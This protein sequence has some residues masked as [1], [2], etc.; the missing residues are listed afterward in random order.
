[1]QARTN[2]GACSRHLAH[3][4]VTGPSSSGSGTCSKKHRLYL[5]PAPHYDTLEHLTLGPTR[6]T[7][8]RRQSDCQPCCKRDAPEKFLKQ[9]GRTTFC[10]GCLLL[11]SA[12][13]QGASFCKRLRPT[14]GSPQ[15][16]RPNKTSTPTLSV[17]LPALPVADVLV[18]QVLDVV[19]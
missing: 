3:R 16:G 6:D 1:M 9:L 2:R 11:C 15:S 4:R 18:E 7:G 13:M 17:I 10:F 12:S 19:I 8:F 14:R 5:Y